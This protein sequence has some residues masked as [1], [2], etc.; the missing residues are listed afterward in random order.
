VPVWGS[1]LS[2]G[3]PRHR[4]HLPRLNPSFHF[5]QA[6]NISNDLMSP[7]SHGLSHSL[8]RP[9]D[10]RQSLI[11]TYNANFVD[12]PLRLTS[13]SRV[14]SIENRCPEEHQAENFAPTESVYDIPRSP[15]PIEH[16]LSL[17]VDGD[18]YLHNNY[19][20]VQQHSDPVPL[21]HRQLNA[22]TTLNT[23]AKKA[24]R[25]PCGTS[26]TRKRRLPV[27]E[28]AL[29]R[30]TTSDGLP[31]PGVR[32]LHGGAAIYWYFLL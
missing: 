7:C 20:P 9:H 19:A 14:S 8:T 28:L 11:M 25:K 4:S 30:T 1:I 17:G 26:S 21:A 24:L 10:A 31:Q 15:K 2:L 18:Q 12:K 32:G 6:H 23:K 29:L 16:R 5:L 3:A 13:F 27:N 22:D